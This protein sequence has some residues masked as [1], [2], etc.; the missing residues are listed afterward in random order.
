MNEYEDLDSWIPPSNITPQEHQASNDSQ[1]YCIIATKPLPVLPCKP[2]KKAGPV[3]L[4]KKRESK[5]PI[6]IPSEPHIKTKLRS[7]PPPPPG[8]INTSLEEP[9]DDSSDIPQRSCKVISNPYSL[10]V[11]C[12]KFEL[13]QLVR[14]CTGHLGATEEHTMS[15]GEELVLFFV[16]TSKVVVASSERG[17]EFYH[18]PLNSSLQFAPHNYKSADLPHHYNTVDHMLKSFKKDELPKVMRVCKSYKGK[19]DESSV[20]TG[21]LIFPRKVSSKKFKPV[22]E[23]INNDKKVKNLEHTCAGDFSINPGDV[24]MYLEDFVHFINHFPISVK[25]FNDKVANKKSFCIDTGTILT[26]EEP[27]PLQ[28][29]ICT[30]DVFGK[31]DYPLMD[32]PMSMPIE[33]ECIQ[34]D[35]FDMSAIFSKTQRTYEN[36]KPSLI[37][38]NMFSSQSTRE[39]LAQQQLYEEVKKDDGTIHI[40]SLEKPN[41]IYEQI[42]AHLTTSET[43]DVENERYSSFHSTGPPLPQRDEHINYENPYCIS[44]PLPQV[45]TISTDS[46]VDDP[47]T[48]AAACDVLDSI[49]STPSLPSSSAAKSSPSVQNKVSDVC[50]SSNQEENIAYLKAYTLADMLQLLENM[51]LGNYKNS[52][53]EQQ[54]DGEIF[55]CLDK[56]DLEDLGVMKSIHQKRLIKLADGTVSAKKYEAGAYETLKTMQTST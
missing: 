8:F 36:F 30:T 10:E 54:I 28:S 53:V 7:P 47:K 31:M 50:T 41:I 14:V 56:S 49:P 44:H 32:L 3:P 2:N 42:P 34:Y 48:A 9:A 25:V 40:Y 15:E 45:S 27:K 19:S 33:V 55:V 29:Y 46:R 16:K 20:N 21:E 6:P 11:F 26:L 5:H 37:K 22:L 38:K 51:N 52:F 13:P 1:D 23:C 17:S 4:P 39:L 12:E 24:K 43:D 35:D 18:I